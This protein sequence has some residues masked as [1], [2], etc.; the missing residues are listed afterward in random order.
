MCPV[1][2][3]NIKW[4]NRWHFLIFDWCFLYGNSQ[5]NQS[6]WASAF[7][8]AFTGSPIHFTAARGGSVSNGGET[9][10]VHH[11]VQGK[12]E[13]ARGGR[14]WNSCSGTYGN[15][16]VFLLSLNER[17]RAGAHAGTS[18]RHGKFWPATRVVRVFGFHFH[19]GLGRVYFTQWLMSL[20]YK[21]KLIFLLLQSLNISFNGLSL[22]LEL[23]SFL[24][25]N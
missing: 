22:F 19:W 3:W 20:Q 8:I 21:L 17:K 10:V 15:V 5:R 25:D 4:S 12:Q 1:A 14:D 9:S 7:G 6:R 24:K 18:G 13:S 2:K 23:F 11:I 16:C